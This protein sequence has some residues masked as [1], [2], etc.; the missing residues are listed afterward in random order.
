MK[1]AAELAP[2]DLR[3]FALSAI[4]RSLR[5]ASMSDGS[6]AALVR[7]EPPPLLR[8]R[9]EEEQA[10]DIRVLVNRIRE[11]QPF[12]RPKLST[13][14]ALIQKILDA[15][16]IA[17]AWQ[18][19][20]EAQEFAK[21]FTR[22]GKEIPA[23]ATR[24]KYTVDS[25][26]NRLRLE[27]ASEVTLNADIKTA[28]AKEMED[29]QFVASIMQMC[30]D[31]R[32]LGQD[33]TERE[34]QL[35]LE[36]A[37]RLLD[38][39][40]RMPQNYQP[41][42]TDEY[43][44][45]QTYLSFA[46]PGDGH[47]AV[48]VRKKELLDG[49]I[50]HIEYIDRDNVDRK[51]L[52]EAYRLP[53]IRNAARVRLHIGNETPCTAFIGR[54]V[55]EGNDFEL[56]LL[57]AGH[58]M[59]SVCSAMFAHGMADCKV[60]MDGMTAKQS[61][62]FMRIVAGNVVRD[63]ITQRL[64][65]AFNINSALNDDLFSRGAP[66]V[67]QDRYQIAKLAV[68]LV[69]LGGFNKVAWDGASN[70]PSVPIVG[71][72]LK[73]AQ[74]LDVVHAAHQSGLETYISAG[75]TPENMRDAV[76]IG[77]GGV[78]IGTK[79]H[80]QSEGVIGEIDP[81]KV[82]Q[83]LTVRRQASTEIYGSAASHLARLDWRYAEGSLTPKTNELRLELF[84]HLRSMLGVMDELLKSEEIPTERKAESKSIPELKSILS[85]QEK[86]L[87]ATLEAVNK[88][89]HLQKTIQD[90]PAQVAT[91]LDKYEPRLGRF[92]SVATIADVESSDLVIAWA[93]R[94]SEASE[95]PDGSREPSGKFSPAD[96]RRIS[97]MLDSH[98]TDGLR[99]LYP[100]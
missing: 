6:A 96:L 51:D 43:R 36:R 15:R 25:K 72:Q 9:T 80:H 32:D 27:T 14:N 13:T 77:V 17:D 64:S 33:I 69:G 4:E 18:R 71:E 42:R 91:K 52:V 49:L 24:Y 63:P 26:Q 60:A 19:L 87:G 88:F 58:T 93:R 46:D 90:Q 2:A 37:Y 95:E 21:S 79:L 84:T 34:D 97:T 16:E 92:P 31:Y 10:S 94:V 38:V 20:K 50:V 53:A 85:E 1:C 54:P 61:V 74:L 44:P 62:S 56:G 70:G 28:L 99:D 82:L 68:T 81:A 41:I 73:R 11:D 66:R 100:L 12:A 76:Y 22:Q 98:D 47:L 55:F 57:K 78:G 39:G 30:H 40:V 8:L 5:A 23:S 83:A 7:R 35:A 75:M 45:V 48:T 59:A 3:L 29:Q 86:N 67:I 89:T 65:A